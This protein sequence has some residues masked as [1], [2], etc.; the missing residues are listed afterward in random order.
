MTAHECHIFH[1]LLAFGE[2]KVPMVFSILLDQ[3][4]NGIPEYPQTAFSD[5]RGF[6][7]IFLNPPV[8]S[9]SADI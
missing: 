2:G 1:T 5:F 6:Q 9:P 7:A 8:D 4:I 3:G